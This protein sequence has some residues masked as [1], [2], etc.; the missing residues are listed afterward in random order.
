MDGDAPRQM[1]GL[2]DG[3][4]F[5]IPTAELT[6]SPTW[7][8]AAA[9]RGTDSN[10]VSVQDVFVPESLA[11]TQTKPLVID[12]PFFR[13]PITLLFFFGAPAIALGVLRTALETAQEELSTKV[14]TFS[15]QR[16][17]DVSAIQEMFANSQAA[18][19]ATRAGLLELT[20]EFGEVISAGGEVP[21]RLKSDL[22]S[23]IFYTLD[24]VR[25][26]VSQLYARGT[27]AGFIHG[28]PVERALRNLHAI[29]F[30]IETGRALQ[31]SAGRV[32]LG[33]EPVHP[34]F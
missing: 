3:R 17:R 27:R 25:E 4:L 12:R 21:I 28:H 5:L 6:I 19:R 29:A 32:Y 26:T 20:D 9:M 18:L 24:V 15:G 10:A 30:G 33:G 31:Q 1:N 2:P 8:Q 7:Q 14:S 13:I 22:Y 16:L 23:S 11:H 34:A